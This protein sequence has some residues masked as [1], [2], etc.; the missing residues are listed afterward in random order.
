MVGF[1]LIRIYGQLVRHIPPQVLRP[2]CGVGPRAGALIFT[3][4]TRD[5][6]RFSVEVTKVPVRWGGYRM[7]DKT[8]VVL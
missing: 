8:F 5:A 6:T 3:F 7:N 4:K 1:D 2:T